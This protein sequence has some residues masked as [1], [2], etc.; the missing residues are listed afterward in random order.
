M[1]L[2]GDVMAEFTEI[3]KIR[4]RMHGANTICT[5]CPLGHKNNGYSINCYDLAM[6]YPKEYERICLEWA[7]ENPEITNRDKFYQV[8]KDTFGEHIAN[9]FISHM[10]NSECALLECDNDMTCKDCTHKGF[11]TRPYIEQK[12]SE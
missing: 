12:E 4:K 5:T 11:W 3:T 7:K 10:Y 1:K 2:R 9:S 6:E 8:M